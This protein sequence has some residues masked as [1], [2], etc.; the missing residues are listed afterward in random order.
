MST[1][2]NGIKQVQHGMKKKIEYW[3]KIPGS[4]FR[5]LFGRGHRI[6]QVQRHVWRLSI[7]TAL[8]QHPKEG[9]FTILSWNKIASQSI[10]LSSIPIFSIASSKCRCLTRLSLSTNT[11]CFLE[12]RWVE[13]HSCRF[14]VLEAVVAGG[15]QR[16]TQILEI[17]TYCGDMAEMGK[18]G[19]LQGFPKAGIGSPKKIE[20]NYS[21]LNYNITAN[22]LA[23]KQISYII[24][25]I[26]HISK[27]NI[28]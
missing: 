6:Q 28:I 9:A 14:Q 8:L 3:C 10:K 16:P 23:N 7:A 19:A 18:A 11:L 12:T 26:F 27:Y 15:V 2:V 20:E 17:G 13:E 1:D 4:P 21:T 5:L 25:N 22:V 24:I